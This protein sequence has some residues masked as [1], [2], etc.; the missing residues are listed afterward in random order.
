M[1]VHR[2]GIRRQSLRSLSAAFEDTDSVP[3]TF[4]VGVAGA[5]PESVECLPESLLA[6]LAG[7]VNLAPDL[8]RVEQITGRDFDRGG[9]V[10]SLLNESGAGVGAHLVGGRSLGDVLRLG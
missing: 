9:T 4:A 5:E 8:P 7:T 3:P 2:S 1:R 6:D 10:T